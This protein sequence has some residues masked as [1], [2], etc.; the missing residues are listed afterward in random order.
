MTLLR[1]S[2]LRFPDVS[3]AAFASLWALIF[4]VPWEEQAAVTQGV[5]VSH[6]VGAAAC[7]MGFLPV[8]IS[9]R[10]RRFHPLHYLLGVLVVWMVATYCWSVAPDLTAVKAG[11]CVR[12]LVLVWLIWQFAT[13]KRQ[14]VSLLAAYVL[15]SYV[16]ALGTVYSFVTSTGSGAVLATNYSWRTDPSR[17]VA[18]VDDQLSFVDD[19]PVVITGMIGNDNHTI[20]LTQGF[21]R[22][23]L[24]LKIVLTA[25][26]NL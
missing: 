10:T 19:P 26:S 23:A 1:I 2:H 18:C 17:C 14:Q 16:S 21:Q 4:C 22:Y 6:L 12:L 9:W 11:Y 8:L 15:G 5:A 25:L 7:V 3:S 13:T 20:V 24:H